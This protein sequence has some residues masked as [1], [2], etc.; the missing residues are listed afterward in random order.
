MWLWLFFFVGLLLM[1]IK[2]KVQSNNKK[3]EL[4]WVDGVE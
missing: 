4:H 1:R 3:N 2:A